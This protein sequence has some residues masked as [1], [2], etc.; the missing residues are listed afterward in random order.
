MSD[1]ELLELAAKAA[2]QTVVRWNDGGEPYSSGQGFVLPGGRLW[3]P[4]ISD[5]DEARL[6]ATMQFCVHWYP[7]CVLVGPNVG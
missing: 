7:A 5:G 2:G 1:K 3:N 6:E 4:L